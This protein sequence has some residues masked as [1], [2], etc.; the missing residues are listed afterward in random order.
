MSDIDFSDWL[1]TYADILASNIYDLGKKACNLLTFDITAQVQRRMNI[2]YDL[3]K[4]ERH[5]VENP[6]E[7]QME[8]M[9]R[10][11]DMTLRSRRA[12]R[13]QLHWFGTKWIDNYHCDC[14]PDD[15]DAEPLHD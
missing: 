14:G 1:Y 3:D 11:F 6:S 13:T 10:I 9:H 7:D 2:D 8:A 15:L 12:V 4:D 5:Y